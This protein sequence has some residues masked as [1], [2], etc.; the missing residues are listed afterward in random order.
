MKYYIEI[1]TSDFDTFTEQ[2]KDDTNW[3]GIAVEP[4]RKLLDNI[5]IRDNTIYENSAITNE[6]GSVYIYTITDEKVL[7]MDISYR[8]LSTFNLNN[9]YIKGRNLTASFN[10]II[11]NGITFKS[12]IEK[13]NFY[14]QL[15]YLKIDTEG[16]DCQVVY[17]VLEYYGNDI[18][19]LPKEIFFEVEHSYY[20]KVEALKKV[21]YDYYLIEDVDNNHNL[22]CKLKNN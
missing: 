12:L 3:S 15:D 18:S 21:L 4:I 5:P 9:D 19:K 8:G 17:Q 6:D 1:G 22:I 10:K 20:S 16:F 11:V 14:N 13:Y 7:N 2:V